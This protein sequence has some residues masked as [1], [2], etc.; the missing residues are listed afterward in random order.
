MKQ[1]TKSEEEIMQ[2]LWKLKKGFVKEIVEQ[3]KDPKPAYNTVSTVIRILE[4]KEF[5]SHKTFGRTHQYFPI[6]SKKEYSRKFLNRIVKNYFENS[7]SK[8][9]SFLSD[10]E[11]LSISEIEKL[12]KEIE[13]IIEN[14]KNNKK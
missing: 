12:K 6:V 10:N 7:T 1:L 13:I 2:F 3:F 9:F 8:M 14:K 11:D 4:E 5:I